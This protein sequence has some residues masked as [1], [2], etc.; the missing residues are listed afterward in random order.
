[1]DRYRSPRSAA[2]LVPVRLDSVEL[3]AT[4][5]PGA[6]NRAADSGISES[7][8]ELCCEGV[9]L[10]PPLQPA[11]LSERRV[12]PSRTG[13]GRQGGVGDPAQQQSYGFPA[14]IGVAWTI[15]VR[16]VEKRAAYSKSPKPSRT[17][18]AV[19]PTR[20]GRAG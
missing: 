17:G 2:C 7:A 14:G 10:D 11:E 12:G 3:A 4:D 1:M 5:G 8:S 16:R 6:T 15:V 19:D 13:A 20:A 18:A 9:G